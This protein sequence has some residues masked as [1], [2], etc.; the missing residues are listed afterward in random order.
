MA[1]ERKKLSGCDTLRQMLVCTVVMI[2]CIL[3]LSAVRG[4]FP[5]QLMPFDR[6]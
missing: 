6:R 2:L 3:V 1:K 5:S 4:A